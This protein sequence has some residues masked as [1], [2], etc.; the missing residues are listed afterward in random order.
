MTHPYV[1]GSETSEAAARAVQTRAP[2]QRQKLV[3]YLLE[4][5]PEGAT[6]DQLKQISGLGNSSVCPRL[7]ELHRDGE[8]VCLTEVRKTRKGLYAYVYV[9]PEY[10]NGRDTRPFE[11]F[12][13]VPF[14]VFRASFPGLSDVECQ[15]HWDGF[16]D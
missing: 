15:E 1:P 3:A 12:K 5:G 2:T 16:G 6:T 10:V 7:R 4:Q 13:L 9:L 8:V 11:P 14:S